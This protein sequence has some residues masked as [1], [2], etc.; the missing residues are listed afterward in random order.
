MT[1]TVNVE[2]IDKPLTF[3]DGT[4]PAIIQQTVK[5]LVGG[6]PEDY[7]TEPIQ[8]EQG[9]YQIGAGSS[10]KP[11]RDYILQGVNQRAKEFED[12]VGGLVEPFMAVGSGMAAYTPAQIGGYT[13]ALLN[14]N[15]PMAGPD[16]RD[17]IQQGLTFTP[18]TESGQNRT[19]AIAEGLA[20]VGEAVEKYGR[21]GEEALNAGAP[22]W[23]ARLIEGVPEYAGALLSLFG[24]AKNAQPGPT[25]TQIKGTPKGDVNIEVPRSTLPPPKVAPSGR[26]EPLLDDAGQTRDALLKGTSD[27]RAAKLKLD[28]ATKTAIPDPIAINAGKKGWSDNVIQITK[29]VATNAA[30][31]IKSIEMVNRAR[32]GLKDP[33][34]GATNRPDQI[35]GASLM[36]RFKVLKKEMLSSGAKVDDVAGKVFKGKNINSGRILARLDDKIAS[37]GGVMD[38]TGKFQYPPGSGLYGAEAAQKLFQKIHNQAKALG[39]NPSGY[40]LHKFKQWVDDQVSISSMKGEG[41]VGDANRF[42]GTWRGDINKLLRK[43]SKQY[44]KINLQYSETK[45]AM[46]GLADAFGGKRL[47][48][49]GAEDV[50]GQLLRRWIGRTANRQQMIEAVREADRVSTKWRT[51]GGVW[52]DTMEGQIL[53]ANALDDLMTSAN[54]LTRST[55]KADIGA[56]RAWTQPSHAIIEKVAEKGAEVGGKAMGYSDDPLKALDAIE[57]LLRSSASQ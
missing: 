7:G 51:D 44:E 53:M 25:Q 57:D 12:H 46:D 30:D 47:Y 27:P 20:P 10:N 38:D 24:L 37:Y 6:A 18:R 28:P 50:T 4:D 22:E 29:T 52:T 19:Q 43:N 5:K 21:W 2:G 48:G 54:P 45:A 49:K 42:I 15:N 39:P 55:F 23:L 14:P 8:N 11:A 16:A 17:R 33:R 56:A 34:W 40:K 36:E 31:R 13:Q 3:P 1:I 41:L 32:K 26:I 35:L 9:Q